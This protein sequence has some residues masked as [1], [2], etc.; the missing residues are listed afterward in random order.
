[1]SKKLS[2]E[3]MQA[4]IAERMDL[5]S[6]KKRA[7]FDAM[8]LEEQYKKI[9]SQEA[10]R[11]FAEKKK[12]GFVTRST[13]RTLVEKIS[14][15]LNSHKISS[16]DEVTEVEEFLKEWKQN[17]VNEAKARIDE[18]IKKLQEQLK[19]FDK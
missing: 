5:I 17:Y 7:A 6:E 13:N 1:M 14:D 16:L 8:D 3:E 19:S 10:A 11:K 18:E 2:I 9:K 15:V 4:Y 12:D